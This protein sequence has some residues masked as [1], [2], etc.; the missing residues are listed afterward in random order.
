VFAV[1]IAFLFV[2]DNMKKPT[3][4]RLS[5]IPPNVRGILISKNKDA[6]KH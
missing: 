3:R 4:Q 1:N 6:R 5:S 2:L